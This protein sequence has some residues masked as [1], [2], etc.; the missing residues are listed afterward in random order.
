ML[1]VLIKNASSRISLR[2]IETIGVATVKHPLQRLQVHRSQAVRQLEAS[3]MMVE[4]AGRHQLNVRPLQ[5]DTP[6]SKGFEQGYARLVI[7]MR[8]HRDRSSVANGS[9][10][11]VLY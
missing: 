11:F 5:A 9:L 4:R 6:R 8:M 2:G 3:R 10:V 7:V 1:R